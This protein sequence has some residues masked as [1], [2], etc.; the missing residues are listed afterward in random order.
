ML[1]DRL[2]RIKH[3]KSALSRDACKPQPHRHFGHNQLIPK[4][5]EARR[6]DFENQRLLIKIISRGPNV[7]TAQSQIDE[8]NKNIVTYKAQRQQQAHQDLAQALILKQKLIKDQTKSR[9][10]PSI[11]QMSQTK[12]KRADSL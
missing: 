1:L 5:Y 9:V 2:L 11:D 6:I 3:K 7:E 4:K 12:S 8:Y 10:F